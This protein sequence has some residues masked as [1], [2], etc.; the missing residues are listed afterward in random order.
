MSEPYKG[1]DSSL[2]DSEFHFTEPLTAL[3]GPESKAHFRI[4]RAESKQTR[5]RDLL[6]QGF[7]LSPLLALMSWLFNATNVSL[8]KTSDS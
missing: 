2:K 5:T 8:K 4:A 1:N 6:G 7:A 3:T